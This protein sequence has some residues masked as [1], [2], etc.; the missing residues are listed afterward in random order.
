MPINTFAEKATKF[1]SVLDEIFQRESI[2]SDLE[3]SG[4]EFIGTK[5]IKKP[6]ISLDGAGDYE[7]D[8]GYVQGGISVEY[9]EHELEF[10]RGRKFRLDVIDNDEAAFDLYRAALTEYVRT[11]E[12]PETDAIRFAR[13]CKYAGKTIEQVITSENALTLYDDA[14][15][16]MTNAHIGF[17]SH[18]M[19]CSAEYYKAL[20]NAKG[21]ER[22][23]GTDTS[24]KRAVGSIDDTSIIKVPKD[25]FYDVIKLLTGRG[26][27]QEAGGYSVVSGTSKEINFILVPK[28]ILQAITKRKNTKTILPE[29]NQQADAYDVMYRCFHDLIVDDNKRPA[30]YVCKKPTAITVEGV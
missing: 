22:R 1:L 8:T 4:V 29:V 5:K 19:Y 28:I 26:D 18:V 20:K 12:I 7:R 2:T 3:I 9:E 21:I 24:I 10:D 25:R 15:E 11:K 14:E 23:F 27:G 13:M 16:Y 30:I 6:K 17:G